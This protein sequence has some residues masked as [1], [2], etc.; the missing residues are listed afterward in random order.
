MTSGSVDVQSTQALG[1]NVG[2]S[3]TVDVTDT[4]GDVTVLSTA[5]TGNDGEASNLGGGA[6]T[7]T[8]VQSADAVSVTADTQ[9]S[10]GLARTGSFSSSTQAVANSQGLAAIDGSI[11]VTVDQTSA[12][13]TQA[14]AGGELQYT[15]GAATA[16]AVGISNNLT[17]VGTGFSTQNLNIS[18]VMTGPRTQASQSF[19]AGNAQ[20]ING[21]ATATANNITIDNEGS[22]LTVAVNQ[23]NASYVRGEVQ[24]SSYEFGAGS[25]LASG[26]GNSVVVGNFGPSLTLNN[27]QVNNGG[28]V[29]TIATFTGH[30]GY[31]S[32]STATAVGN[33]VTGYACT[34]CGGRMTVTN[35]QT[36]RSNIGAASGTTI[37][38]S[39]RS[40]TGVAAASGNTATFYVSSPN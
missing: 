27:T 37:T 22:D 16:S 3:T 24:L 29:E 32:Y 33:G 9:H 26:V 39:G 36:N 17:S 34:D 30:N 31:D 20:E 35:N 7:G 4:S 11:D 2:A 12:A 13:L 19:A 21:V 23:D 5:A 8:F 18:Q 28:G 25:S 38:G 1:G 40:V 6:L 14:D 15:Q 10:A